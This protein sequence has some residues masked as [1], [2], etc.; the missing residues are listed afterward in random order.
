MNIEI[1]LDDAMMERLLLRAAEQEVSAEE[2]IIQ[3][4]RNFISRGDNIG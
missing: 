1:E 3:T 4:I 2:L